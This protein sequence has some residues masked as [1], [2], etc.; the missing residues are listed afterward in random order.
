[1]TGKKILVF[2]TFFGVHPICLI[3][4]RSVGVVGAMT[5]RQA[6]ARRA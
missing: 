2:E 6:A 3:N 5:T 4:R 1:M